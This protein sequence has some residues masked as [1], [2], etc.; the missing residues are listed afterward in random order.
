M[1]YTIK[2]FNETEKVKEA[3]KEY[4]IL[5]GEDFTFKPVPVLESEM[6]IL[7]MDAYHIAQRQAEKDGKTYNVQLLDLRLDKTRVDEFSKLGLAVEVVE[8]GVSCFEEG[9]EYIYRASLEWKLKDWL[10][11]SYIRQNSYSTFS[12][13]MTL[14]SLT[15]LSM[16]I[17]REF[18]EK[19][20]DAHHVGRKE[21]Q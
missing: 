6:R 10:F 1:K 3:V 15:S 4:K 16:K 9:H 18:Y 20:A 21:V 12:H 11:L 7:L 2:T 17:G 8:E 5:G 13:Q 14:P 19:Y